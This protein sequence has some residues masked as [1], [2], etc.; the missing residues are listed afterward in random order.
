MF[1]T[2]LVKPLLNILFAIYAVIPGHDFGVAVILLTLLVR[3]I[4]W[5]L[6]TRQLHSQK[7]MQAMQ[8][9]IAK[10]K[11]KAKGDRQKETEMLME[12]YKEKGTNPFASLLPLLIQLPIFFAL[13]AVLR[14]SIHTDQIAKLLYEPVKQLN[15]VAHILAHHSEFSPTLFGLIDLTKPSWI[16][17][18]MAGAAQYYQTRQ[19][20]ARQKNMDDQAKMMATATSLFPILTVG[21]GLTLPSALALYWVV[22]SLVAIVQQHLV[23][24]RDAHEMEE[25]K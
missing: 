23:L 12:L 21:I 20:T 17:A 6:V 7:A 16:L 8:P 10:I 1:N 2:L 11:A 25:I 24:V 5:P 13:Y 15:E 9:E 14:D 18:L 3:L 22:T 4:L 19:L